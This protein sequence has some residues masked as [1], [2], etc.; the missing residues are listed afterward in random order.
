MNP[1]GFGQRISSM[2]S[3]LNLHEDLGSKLAL[4]AV[5]VVGLAYPLF[6]GPYYLKLALMGLLYAYLSASWNIVGGYGGQLS[7]A[8]GI[9]FGAGSYTVALFSIHHV[10][11]LLFA[12][13]ACL[14][15]AACISF[16]IARVCF[17]YALGGIH[18]AVGTML[19]AEIVRIVAVNSSFLG[20]SQGLQVQAEHSIWNLQF[21]SYLPFYYVLLAMTVAIAI[22]T[23][24]LQ[25][26]RLGF[27][28]TALREQDQSAKALGVDTVR[29]KQRAFI[30]SAALTAAGGAVHTLVIGFVEPDFNLGLLLALTIVMGAVLGG[31]G[32]VLGPIIGGFIV[33]GVQEALIVLGGLVGTTSVSALAQVVYGMFFVAIILGFP[34]GIVGTLQR[35]RFDRQA[36]LSEANEVAP[37]SS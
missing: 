26:S 7:L 12:I 3:K 2:L 23:F 14:V 33:Q 20:R 28:L 17:S 6:A 32:T 5:L 11:P 18:F 15:V 13:P 25:R 34:R 29:T 30:I 22:G 27:Q 1:L 10:A 36:V 9:F 16:V 37:A 31:R 24:W 4:L 21:D 19:L 8:H 35:L